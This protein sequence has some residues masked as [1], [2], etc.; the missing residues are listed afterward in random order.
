MEHVAKFIKENPDILSFFNI[1][2][3]SK[4][5][6]LSL[7]TLIFPKINSRRQ[8]KMPNLYS[9]ILTSYFISENKNEFISIFIK[10]KHG[11]LNIF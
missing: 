2:T 10:N 7:F 5:L 6:L 1:D 9:Y 11:H 3:I 8:Y 4:I